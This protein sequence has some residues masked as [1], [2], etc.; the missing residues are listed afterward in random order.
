MRKSTTM[1]ATRAEKRDAVTALEDFSENTPFSNL[2]MTAD[3]AIAVTTAKT[4]QA[5]I[6]RMQGRLDEISDLRGAF[7]TAKRIAADGE[8]ELFFPRAASA[9]GQAETLLVTL[10]DQFDGLKTQVDTL[11]NGVDVAKLKKV[12][13]GVESASKEIRKSLDTL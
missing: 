5:A 2:G 8:K 11:K 13:K 1:A 10:K 3:A 7:R 6:T 12:A 4:R 9:L